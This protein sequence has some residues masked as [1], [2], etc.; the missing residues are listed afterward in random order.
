MLGTA[1]SHRSPKQ[2]LCIPKK[3]LAEA[4]QRK[5]LFRWLEDCWMHQLVPQSQTLLPPS[6]WRWWG[7]AGS[8]NEMIFKVPIQPK[9]FYDS[10]ILQLP[11]AP[12][13]PG[14]YPAG[15][16]TGRVYGRETCWSGTKHCSFSGAVLNKAPPLLFQRQNLSSASH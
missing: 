1:R 10:T 2:T 15:H 6:L 3:V 13:V 16:I 5:A 14:K 12:R 7:M 9:P 8:W 11:A 4:C